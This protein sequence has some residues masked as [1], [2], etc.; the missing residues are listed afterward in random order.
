MRRS[1]HWSLFC[2]TA[3]LPLV[4]MFVTLS[5]C[6]TPIDNYFRFFW[7]VFY[8]KSVLKANITRLTL[9]NKISFNEELEPSRSRYYKQSVLLETHAMI[10]CSKEWKSSRKI[11]SELLTTKVGYFSGISSDLLF[12]IRV[13]YLESCLLS[14]FIFRSPSKEM[15]KVAHRRRRIDFCRCSIYHFSG[16]SMIF[17]VNIGYFC[18]KTCFLCG[19]IFRQFETDW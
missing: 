13:P 15:T 1:C 11:R 14:V 7:F 10:L 9:T 17:N 4:H 6:D 5:T 18:W 16:L 3:I 8:W 2:D 19:N 12:S